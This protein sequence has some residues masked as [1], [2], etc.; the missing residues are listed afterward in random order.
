MS[1]TRGQ[2]LIEGYLA[3]NLDET[4][5]VELEQWLLQSAEARAAFWKQARFHA[6]LR[7]WGKER[8]G[9]ALAA[10]PA[11]TARKPSVSPF[12]RHWRVGVSLAAAAA[13]MLFI[14]IWQAWRSTPR[15]TNTVEVE[16]VQLTHARFAAPNVGLG[17]HA[18]SPIESLALEEGEAL[19]R[20]PSGVQLTLSG[21]THVRFLDRM[22]AQVLTGKVTVDVGAHGKGFVLDTPVTRV[23]DLGTRFGV[24]TL[25]NG[26]TSVMVIQGK[27]ELEHPGQ[28]RVAAQLEQGEAVHVNPAQSMTRIVNITGGAQLGEW[29]TEPPRDCT[30]SE[31]RDNIA[32]EEHPHYYRIVPH[33][34]KSGAPAYTDRPHA[35]EAADFPA[36]LVGADVVQTF[37]W[38]LR[39]DNF[40]IDVVLTRPAELFVI[41][42]KRGEPQPWLLQD[43]TRTEDV[44]LL[45]EFAGAHETPNPHPFEVWKRTVPHAGTIRL[46]P[47]N[48]DSDGRPV[49]M[50]GI[51]AKPL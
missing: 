32:L 44:L 1:E 13:V 50:Y 23:V 21:A 49:S 7:R 15:G 16:V 4:A 46:G 30:I 33:G 27:V 8:L 40:A 36:A 22:H 37:F 2:Q 51:A 6:L 26:A 34:L 35:W 9:R 39:R 20:L 12:R 42:P 48:R 25:S 10:L 29:S 3:G 11:E 19:L 43:F 18:R 41:M 47:T 38:A 14:A 28:P 31:L 24:E 17:E 5:R 45:R